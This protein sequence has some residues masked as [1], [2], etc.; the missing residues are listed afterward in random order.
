VLHSESK[1]EACIHIFLGMPVSLERFILRALLE[2]AHY[3]VDFAADG[4]TT[5]QRLRHTHHRYLVLLDLSLPVVNGAQLLY[6]VAHEQRLAR[7][8]YALFVPEAWSL[9][10]AIE[11]M[12]RNVNVTLIP[13]L[14]PDARKCALIAELVS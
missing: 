5:L 14:L 6:T 3:H 13:E 2:Q 10:P 12:L 1:E 11:N 4:K 7:H 8:R 9:A